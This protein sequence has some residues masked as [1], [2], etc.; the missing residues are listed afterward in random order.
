MK[1][2]K[3]EEVKRLASLRDNPH[4][5]SAY[6]VQLL[7]PAHGLE[8][9]RA[10]VDVLAKDPV[11]ESR[12][13][14]RKLYLHYARNNGVRDPGT[15]TRTAILKALRPIMRPD[16]KELVVD[17]VTTYEFLPPAY[18][19][20]AALLRSTAII[21]LGEL[22]DE[23]T[24]FFAT[25]LLADGHTEPMSGEPALTAVRV[26]AIQGALLPLYFFAV[27]SQFDQ[28]K[29]GHPEVLSECLRSLSQAPDSVV[30]DLVV[31]FGET[32]NR[33]ALVGLVDMLLDGADAPRHG[34]FLLDFLHNGRDIDLYRY[35]ATVMVTSA[36]AN[37]RKLLVEAAQN[38]HAAERIAVL[39]EVLALAPP[40]EEANALRATFVRHTAR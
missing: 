26:L 24:E 32:E 3:R 38:E 34:D 12:Q 21:L 1:K 40:T 6:A 11:P 4:E 25:R 36:N 31:A 14:L 17:A 8:A 13:A 2:P 27:Q 18:T 28:E 35:T 19:E 5:Q 29:G 37:V 23:L 22:D 10:A 30:H 9:V 33:A 20:E 15:Y 39:K 16:D 7:D